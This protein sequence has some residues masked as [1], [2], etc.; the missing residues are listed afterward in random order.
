MEAAATPAPAP[1]RSVLVWIL[2]VFTLTAIL[3]LAM[4]RTFFGPDGRFGL[5]EGDIWS[6]GNSQRF[7]DPYSFSHIG[8]GLLF[9]ALLWGVAR[10]LD[11]RYRLLIAT[12]LEGA[13]E[14][15]ENSPIIINRY[16]QA[17]IAVGY[18]GDSVFNSL[19][20][21]LMMSLGFF[22]ASKVRPWQSV[23]ILAAME[24]GCLFAV[25]DN[26]TLNVLMLIYPIHAIKVW[27]LAGRRPG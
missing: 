5:W 25:R 17:T 24:L 8:H 20:D 3:E 13:W 2:G 4:G 15:L 7:A 21:I 6:A 9:F 10:K 1:R 14:I 11:L 26:L 19:S 18:A 22:L 16:R 23:A 27:Q 12:V